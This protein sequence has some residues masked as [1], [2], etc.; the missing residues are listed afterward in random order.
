MSNDDFRSPAF[1]AKLAGTLA[2]DCGPCVQLMVTMAE[3]GGVPADT[4]R[5][6]LRGDDTALDADVLLSVRFARASLAR[7]PAADAL[8]EQVLARWGKLAATVGSSN[9]AA[10]SPKMVDK[11]NN[12]DPNGT[13][14]FRHAQQ[15]V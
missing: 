15:C 14:T 3:R 2:E 9:R 8:R 6:V 7:D 5:A 1:A 11:P 4:L 13:I 10:R 12:L